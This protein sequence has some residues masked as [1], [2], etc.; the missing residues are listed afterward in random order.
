[1][2]NAIILTENENT[3]LKIFTSANPSDQEFIIK[4][5]AC[6]VKFGDVFFNEVQEYI[7]NKDGKAIRSIVDKYSAMLRAEI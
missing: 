5:L 1:M 7:K 6:A 4:A 2:T 3:L